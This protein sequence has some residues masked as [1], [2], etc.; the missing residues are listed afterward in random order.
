MPIS[1]LTA[2]D[3]LALSTFLYILFAFRDHRRRRGFPYPPGPT[4]LPLIGNL[5]DVPMLSPWVEYAKMS[6]KYGDIISFQVLGEVVVVLNSPT[7]IKDL[8]DKRGELYSDRTPFPIFESDL[9]DVVWMLPMARVSNYWREGRKLIERSFRP[10]ASAL[11]RRLIEERVH[12][13]LGWLLANPKGFR[14]HIHYLQGGL[15]VRLSYGYDL[16]ENDDM[17]YPPKR[18][19]DIMKQFF[20]PGTALVNHFP[21]LKRLPSW[22]PLFKYEPLASE[23]RQLVRRMKD[24]PLSFVRK[25]MRDG[26]GIP[27]IASE[28]LQDIDLLSG[29]EHERAEE[30]IKDVLGS[31]F[32]AGADTACVLPLPTVA[33]MSSLFL[34]L[35]LYPEVQ[36]RAQAELDSVLS[37]DR[38]PTYEDRPRLPYIDAMTKEI[39]RW[40]I[41]AP[42]AVP[43][44]PTED[45]F[46]RGYFIPKGAMVVANAW[47][48]LHDPE[49]YPDPEAFKPERFLDKDGNFCDDPLIPLAFGAG[50]RHCPGRHFVDTVLFV[51]TASML[52]VFN[53]TNAKDKDGNDIPVYPPPYDTVEPDIAI[54][55]PEFE[56]SITPRD[57]IAEDLIMAT[58]SALS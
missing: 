10:G 16:K 48:V 8:F 25:G 11:D 33:A 24:E 58:R 15:L 57:K 6:K 5:R 32:Q 9:L 39:M 3:C 18:V 43:H 46:Y 36:K 51:Q 56:C 45:D 27:S 29:V 35:V 41:V 44:A 19:G 52:S 50:R 21:I 30:D 49:L 37:R 1:L 55:L 7:A 42:M 17:L 53:V 2:V 38:L 26:T 31:L 34:A 22:V 14:D 40:H 23:S 4:P 47:G 12:V 13:Y 54:W 20:A 28:Y